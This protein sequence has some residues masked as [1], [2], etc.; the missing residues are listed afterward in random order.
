MMWGECVCVLVERCGAEVRVEMVD[1]KG[2]VK[3]KPEVAPK[4]FLLVPKR[5]A[6]L[7]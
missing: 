3:T 5:K 2:E 4:S 6:T 1:V 7:G